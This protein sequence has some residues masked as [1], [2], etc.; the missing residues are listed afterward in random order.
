MHEPLNGRRL[1]VAT[2]VALAAGGTVA[3]QASATTCAV[4]NFLAPQGVCEVKYTSVGSTTFQVPAGV[5]AIDLLAVGAGGGGANTGGSSGGGGG[6]QVKWSLGLAVTPTASYAVTVGGGGSSTDGG[7]YSNGGTGGDSV[8]GSGISE[9]RASGGQ[10]GQAS[11]GGSSAANSSWASP[12]FPVAGGSGN[13]ATNGGGGGGAGTAAVGGTGTA[14]AP[15]AGGSGID[16]TGAFPGLTPA[17][18]GGGGGGGSFCGFSNCG[19]SGGAGG[20]GGGGSGA[21]DWPIESRTPPTANTGGGGG[22]HSQLWGG[23]TQGGV[24]GSY[25]AAG[26]VVVRYVPLNPP[27][28]PV[29]SIATGGNGEATITVNPGTGSGGAPDS[30]DVTA[31]PGNGT[32]TITLPATTCTITGLA[33]GTAYTFTATATNA[34]GTSGPSVASTSV[35]PIGPPDPPVSVIA[36]GGN[37]SA[38]ISWSAPA[39]DGGSPITGYTVTASPGGGTCTTTGALSCTITGLANGT[40]YT[41]AATATNIVGASGPSLA[42]MSVTPAAP[43]APPAPPAPIPGATPTAQPGSLT[44]DRGTMRVPVRTTGPG[45]VVVLGYRIGGPGTGAKVACTSKARFTT[46]GSKSL[47]CVPTTAAQA[48]RRRGA[49]R[50]R[51]VLVFTTRGAKA[52]RTVVGTATMS[53]IAVP[54]VPVTG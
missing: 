45:T 51:V 33:N 3:S 27:D 18:Y 17:A 6:G 30:F 25:G 24:G 23:G 8:F 42:S 52:Q 11:T 48:L 31:T 40:G 1:L 44:V 22:G 19:W 50:M 13:G 5:T 36:T 21:N 9:V 7:S 53:R 28:A 2:A 15:G 38:T 12:P 41:F 35:T 4:G 46:A 37:A 49:V 43:P 34:A 10:G 39:F 47:I 16:V 14:G 26:I 32:C 29:I 54:S 20:T